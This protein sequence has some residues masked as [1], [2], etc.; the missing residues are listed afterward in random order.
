MRPLLK[1]FTAELKIGFMDDFTRQRG[2]EASAVAMDVVN[3]CR[4][5]KDMGWIITDSKCELNHSSK[6][7]HPF[8]ASQGFDSS[9]QVS[10]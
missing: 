2:R 1:D 3:L 10:L 7:A 4:T 9:N 5:G 8:S 6:F